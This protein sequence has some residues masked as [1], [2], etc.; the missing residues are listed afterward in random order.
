METREDLLKRI[1]N[2]E[3]KL[4]T[5]LE[6]RLGVLED[7]EEIQR[8]QRTYGYYIDL[9][10]WDPMADLFAD[11]GAAIEIGSRGRYLGKDNVLKF[12]RDV[13]GNGLTGLRRLQ[14]INHMQGQGIVTVSPDRTHAQGRWRGVVQGGGGPQRQSIP[15]SAPAAP[16]IG[17]GPPGSLS[18]RRHDV[19]GRRLREYV[20]QG[21]RRLEDRRAVLGADVLRFARLRVHVVPER[22]R[23]RRDA[24]AARA[25]STPGIPGTTVHAVP[26][27][28]SDY[29]CGRSTLSWCRRRLEASIIVVQRQISR[30]ASWM[31]SSL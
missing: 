21:E 29:R 7:I 24:A 22:G 17:A 5:V 11:R 13:N 30:P 14:V 19:C 12:L 15:G 1:A 6:S 3:H 28:P 8:L 23:Q 9:C 26:L 25:N 10:L 2:L 20:R 4:D 18:R 16:A 27:R 31:R